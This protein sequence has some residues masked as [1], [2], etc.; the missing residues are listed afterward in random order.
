MSSEDRL[1]DA[2]KAV[3]AELPEEHWAWQGSEMHAVEHCG[4]IS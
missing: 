4:T 2:E 3:N 1:G